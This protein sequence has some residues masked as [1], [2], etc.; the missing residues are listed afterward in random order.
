M[1]WIEPC[2]VRGLK[3]GLRLRLYSRW[4]WRRWP[5]DQLRQINRYYLLSPLG[6]GN[7]RIHSNLSLNGEGMTLNASSETGETDVTRSSWLERWRY[8]VS[9]CVCVIF[10]CVYVLLCVLVCVYV[11]DVCVCVCV[12]GRKTFMLHASLS[13][14]L[15]PHNLWQ[16]KGRGTVLYRQH[17]S[18]FRFWRT[19]GDFVSKNFESQVAY[20][21]DLDDNDIYT[22]FGRFVF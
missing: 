9:L 13:I 8:C 16:W 18:F 7:K 3:G 11:C 17:S 6:I 12:F 5:T 14:A 15:N 10:W 19:G 22:G 20:C 21:I 2:F 4:P 1:V